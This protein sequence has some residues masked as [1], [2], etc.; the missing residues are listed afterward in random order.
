MAGWGRR[1]HSGKARDG[2]TLRVAPSVPLPAAA[3]LPNLDVRPLRGG[4]LAGD[5]DGLLPGG[6]VDQEET[7]DDLLALGEGAVDDVRFPPRTST[8]TPSESGFKASLALS[9][10]RVLRS[11]VKPSIRS[12]ARRPS[13]SDR[14]RLFS[15]CSTMSS[16]YGTSAPL[17]FASRDVRLLPS[18]RSGDSSRRARMD[19][20]VENFNAS[21]LPLLFPLSPARGRGSG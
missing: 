11:S 8:R 19:Q 5:R 13:S 20:I 2:F 14:L 3:D 6:A 18:R 17:R 1:A 4:T 16:M 9:T 12:Y 7:P 10:P 15:G 21:P